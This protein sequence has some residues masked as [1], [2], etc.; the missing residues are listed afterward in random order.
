MWVRG[1]QKC[2][3]R[4]MVHSILGLRVTFPYEE[5]AGGEPKHMAFY[6]QDGAGWVPLMAFNAS[7]FGP[8]WSDSKEEEKPAIQ[9]LCKTIEINGTK[10]DS[11]VFRLI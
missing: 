9:I 5:G 2:K 11:F 6:L 8:I 1:D 3:C 7:G 10:Q 4:G